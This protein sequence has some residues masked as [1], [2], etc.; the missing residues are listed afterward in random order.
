[1]YILRT[2]AVDRTAKQYQEERENL[3]KGIDRGQKKDPG[4]G[5]APEKGRQ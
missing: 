4:S 1:M 5:E 3:E 2:V